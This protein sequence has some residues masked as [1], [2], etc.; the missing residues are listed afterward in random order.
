MTEILGKIR[1]DIEVMVGSS[2]GKAIVQRLAYFFWRERSRTGI[3]CTESI[4]EETLAFD[5]F[6]CSASRQV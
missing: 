1:E 4:G 3:M 6:G 2:P 5:N